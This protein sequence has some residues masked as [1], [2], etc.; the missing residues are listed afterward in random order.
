MTP[1]WKDDVA[2]P[3]IGKSPDM[4][5]VFGQNP[6]NK[7]PKAKGSQTTFLGT[8]AVPDAS[9]RGQKTLIGM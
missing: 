4:P 3:K 8:D 9:S 6:A 7:K 1:E 2:L 5:P